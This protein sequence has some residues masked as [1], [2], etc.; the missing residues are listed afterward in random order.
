[1]QFLC[2]RQNLNFRAPVFIDERIEATVTVAAIRGEKKILSVRC[3][4]PCDRPFL[5]APERAH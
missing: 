1:M 5:V 4:T 3:A 2:C